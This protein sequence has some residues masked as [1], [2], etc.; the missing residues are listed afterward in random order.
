MTLYLTNSLSGK[1]EVFSPL[2]T[3]LVK[4]YVCGPTVYDLIHIGNARSLVVYD[5]LYRVLVDIYGKES[6]LYVRNITDVDEKINARSKELKVS[7]FELT[8]DTIAQFHIDAQYL[9]CLAPNIEPRATQHISDMIEMIKSL[10]QN[11][12]AYIKNGTVYFQVSSF[13]DYGRLSGRSLEELTPG[14][15]IDID[16][17]KLNSCDFVLWKPCDI[18]DDESAIFD[19]PWGRGQPGWHIE[20][21]SMAYKYLGSDFDI[22]GG[23]LDLIFP[24]HTNEIAQSV[25]AFPGSKFARF[26]VHNG[27]LKVGGQKMS[28]SLNNF[29]T[30][31]DIASRNICP[32]VLR[33]VLLN[34]HYHKPLDFNDQALHEAQKNI[35]YL[36]RLCQD[37]RCVNHQDVTASF[38]GFLFDNLNTHSA[39]GYL[40]ALAK[41]ANKNSQ[42][43][44]IESIKYCANFLG[45]SL[46]KIGCDLSLQ[47]RQEIDD[48]VRQRQVAKLA[49]NLVLADEI[50]DKLK[51]QG[52][53]I[54]DNK[55]GQTTWR[56]L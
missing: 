8:Q 48:L 36:Q 24:H 30:V 9:N 55:Q 20:C 42:I 14:V 56:K 40:L 52:V 29:L 13:G 44:I 10:L 27:F 12:C 22:H 47:E 28:K 38:F 53:A 6:V 39:L 49:K 16:Q 45:L 15:R 46:E 21:S 32:D 54:Q 2:D 7:I 3:K 17:Q 4:M 51:S 19:S 50:R 25:C 43:R 33:Y 23:G 35:D 37:Q 5:V 1:K 11:K 41:Q 18:D 26:W 34:T 31:R